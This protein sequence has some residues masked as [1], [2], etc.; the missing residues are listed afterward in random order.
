MASNWKIEYPDLVQYKYPV[1]TI[2]S[3]KPLHF[4]MCKFSQGTVSAPSISLNKC[5]GLEYPKLDC[6]ILITDILPKRTTAR[7]I[8]IWG[9]ENPENLCLGDYPGTTH[10]C[11]PHPISLDEVPDSCRQIVMDNNNVSL[12]KDGDKWQE[13]HHVNNYVT[14]RFLARHVFDIYHLDPNTAP[15]ITLLTMRHYST[16][17]SVL[18]SLEI[19]ETWFGT[20]YYVC[21]HSLIPLAQYH[22]L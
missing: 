5:T 3:P 22:L 17:A 2:T 14:D 6:Q 1:L 13:L 21:D 11:L 8:I 18:H 19:A 7:A 12:L 4:R 20:R 15:I 16:E 9:G 10:W